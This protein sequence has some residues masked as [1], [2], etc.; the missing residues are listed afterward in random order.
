MAGRLGQ[1]TAIGTE[2]SDMVGKQDGQRTQQVR[3]ITGTIIAFATNEVVVG[4]DGKEKTTMVK[5]TEPMKDGFYR[6]I[7]Q[8]DTGITTTRFLSLVGKAE[9]HAGDKGT[10]SDLL[11]QKCIISYRG[12]SVN[13]GEI[14]DVVDSSMDLLTASAHNQ[15]PITGTAFA[16]P[17]NG[18]IG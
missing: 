9:R 2:L 13:R 8:T 11:K 4:K 3:Q 12:P 7:V 17:G 16:P 14:I 18:I 1:N 15:L 5:S 6:F 10:P